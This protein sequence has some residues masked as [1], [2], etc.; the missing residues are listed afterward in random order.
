[1]NKLFDTLSQF[2]RREQLL[3]L[4]GVVAFSLYLVWALFLSPLQHKRALLIT[5]NTALEQSYGQVQL[6]VQQIKDQL[7]QSNQS[8]GGGA[9]NINGLINTSLSENGISMSAFQ[10]GTG[11]EVR[12]RIDKTSSDSLMQWMYDLE[13][14]HHV[15]IRE[16]SITSSN[17]PGQVAVNIRLLKP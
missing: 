7:Q 1:M 16:L 2:N 6:M 3:I 5:T 13:V 8:I 12:V 14:K 15:S 9:E 4:I 10:P 11:G 17:D